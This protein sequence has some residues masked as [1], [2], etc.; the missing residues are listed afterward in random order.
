MS[1]SNQGSK[2][3][4]IPGQPDIRINGRRDV[5]GCGAMTGARR[6]GQRHESSEQVRMRGIVQTTAQAN[7]GISNKTG[8]NMIGIQSPRPGKPS[9]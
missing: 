4:D 7:P 6:A 8:P 9:F 2:G 3:P 1:K 5:S